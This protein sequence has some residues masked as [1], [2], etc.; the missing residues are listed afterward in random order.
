MKKVFFSF[1][2]LFVFCESIKS[3]NDS[4]KAKHSVNLSAS[5]SGDFYFI[6]VYNPSYRL[7]F[8][9]NI[10]SIGPNFVNSY[11]SLSDI[12]QTD[13]QFSG[14]S[15]GYRHNL[16]KIKKRINFLVAI[17]GIYNYL[18]DK[19]ISQRDHVL[20]LF[21]GL[22]AEAYLSKKIYLNGSLGIGLCYRK[23]RFDFPI[24]YNEANGYYCGGV[25]LLKLGIG[26]KF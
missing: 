23:S 14:F 18:N 4:L 22:E 15:I 13:F 21:G 17:D 19:I 7:Y 8:K 25:G 26:Y 6:G 5:L 2:V 24:N 16:T 11:L 9:R 3:E 20:E 12:Y 1:V 10:F